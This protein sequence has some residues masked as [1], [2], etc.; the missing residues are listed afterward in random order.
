MA[1]H[2][3][4]AL[5]PSATRAMFSRV[6][7]A[8]GDR[9]WWRVSGGDL[10]L[11]VLLR[12]GLTPEGEVTCTGLALGVDADIPPRLTATALHSIRLAAIVSQIAQVLG[13]EYRERRFKGG[14]AVEF[15]GVE[16]LLGH[17]VDHAPAVVVPRAR[18]GAQGH[19]DASLREVVAVFRRALKEHPH[20]PTKATAAAT[21]YSDANVRY[22]LRKAR[23]RGL[24]VPSYGEERTQRARSKGRKQ[25]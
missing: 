10:P 18:P 12:L 15:A 17:F 2:R 4:E 7:K 25:R 19:S 9:G 16:H 3:R 11:P 22:M 20:A 13:H 14:T 21:N 23:N 6:T 24:D 5:L 1:G 8:P